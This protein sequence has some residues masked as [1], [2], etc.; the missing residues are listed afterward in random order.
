MPYILP[1]KRPVFAPVVNLMAEMRTVTNLYIP[2]ILFEYC[3][4]YVKPSYNNYKNFRGELAETIDEINRRSCD[5]NFPFIDIERNSS[6]DWRKVVSLM[7]KKEVQA[8]GDLNFIL[9]TYC[10]YHVINRLGFCHSLE[11]CR[12]MI[13][14][15]LM[16]PYEDKRK[17]ENGDV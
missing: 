8:D 12:K 13:G 4:K 10:M 17:Q 7:H 5:F 9:F 14:V 6:G 3:K 2:N 15:E 1:G 16:T 11:V